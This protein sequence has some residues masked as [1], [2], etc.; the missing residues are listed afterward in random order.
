MTKTPKTP[1]KDLDQIAASIKKLTLYLQN[2]EIEG[3]SLTATEIDAVA[4]KLQTHVAEL[5]AA[6]Q[7]LREEN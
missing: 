2:S 1:R 3:R 7:S 5:L 4:N 6:S